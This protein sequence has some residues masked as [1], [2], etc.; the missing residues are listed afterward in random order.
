MFNNLGLTAVDESA[1]EDENEYVEGA[2]KRMPQG[3]HT[4]VINMA[5]QVE[6]QKGAIGVNFNVT[7]EDG[8]TKGFTLYATSGT[9]KGQSMTYTYQ[10]RDGNQKTQFMKGYLQIRA[11]VHAALGVDETNPSEREIDVFDFELKRDVKQR[12]QVYLDLVGKPVILMFREKLEDDWQDTSKSV[13]KIELEHAANATTRLT[14]AE[15][16]KGITEPAIIDAFLAGIEKDPVL[17]KRKQ[18]K[19][20]TPQATTGG[21][22]GSASF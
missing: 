16:K 7:N 2:S 8:K 13:T 11:I 20:H 1:L 22:T 14:R 6:S 15:E 17:D 12:K 19:G 18:S 3:A 9:E 5:Y 10:D 21:G 4:C